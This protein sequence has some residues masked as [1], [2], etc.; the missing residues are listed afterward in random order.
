MGRTLAEKVW[1]EHVVRTAPGEPD[2]LTLRA[3]QALQNAD[4]IVYDERVALAVL[5]RARRDAER[6]VIGRRCGQ[7][8]IRPDAVADLLAEHARAGRSVACL[9]SRKALTGAVLC[10]LRQAGLSVNVV[11][12]VAAAS[13][14]PTEILE[15]AA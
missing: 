9:N 10:R 5:D 1:D 6:I 7:P 12:V 8:E 15:I 2:L 14:D 4:V 3:L 11:P 13:A